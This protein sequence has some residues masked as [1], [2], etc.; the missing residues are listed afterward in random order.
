MKWSLQDTRSRYYVEWLVF[1]VVL[2]LLALMLQSTRVIRWLDNQTY[3]RL[4]SAQSA[5]TQ[6]QSDADPRIVIVTID[7]ESLKAN[8]QWPWPRSTHAKLLEQI[9]AAQP[10]GVALDLILTEPAIN[11]NDDR[12]LA[13]ALTHIPNSVL[14]VL[15]QQD[16]ANDAIETQKPVT[17]LSDQTR[18]GHINPLIDLDG[19]LREIPMTLIDQN[20]VTWSTLTSQLLPA[21]HQRPQGNLRIPFA[22][23]ADPFISIPY[24]QVLRGQV[25][26]ELLRGRYVL[27]GSTAL[28]LGDRYS[29]PVSGNLG[30]APGI[31]VHANI[32]ATL[33]DGSA[34]T[35]PSKHTSSLLALVPIGLLMVLLFF[36]HER[37]HL[38]VFI[39]VV[40]AYVLFTSYALW[41][42]HVWLPPVTTLLA[43]ALGY[44]LWSWRRLVVL[45]SHI[46]RQLHTLQD[47]TGQL[48]ALLQ[49]ANQRKPIANLLERDLTYIHQLYQFTGDALNHNPEAQIAINDIGEIVLANQKAQ[50][51]LSATPRNLKTILA[52]LA[53][54]SSAWPEWNDPRVR[55]WSW[56][57]ERECETERQRTYQLH[58]T[59]ITF[60]SSDQAADIWLISLIDLTIE[61]Q[62]ATQRGE[63]IKFLSHDMRSPQ[64]DIL[65][66]L[67][68]RQ[69]TPPQVSETELHQQIQERVYKTLDWAQEMVGL[70]EAQNQTLQLSE[71]NFWY[72]ADEALGQVRAQ[73]LAKNIDL[74]IQPISDEIEQHGWV[75]VDGVL[76]ERVLINLLNN[77][78]RYSSSESTIMLT[79][80]R[81][82]LEQNRY[83]VC[84]IQDQGY[85]ISTHQLK[86]LAQQGFLIHQPHTSASPPQTHALKC[87]GTPPQAPDRAG[88]LGV[89]L[90]MVATTIKQHGGCIYIKTN[91][92]AG[93]RIDLYLPEVH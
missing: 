83:I 24:D 21:E 38:W 37:L 28:G 19:V 50:N 86:Q 26:H 40:M 63:L 44:L 30:P 39:A 77:A 64:V 70:T 33:L 53:P 75:K 20:G 12:L 69:A 76:I 36:I 16:A 67:E 66:L 10:A 32:L 3:D 92:Q 54:N 68:L 2:C 79:F 90:K 1:V 51:I 41:Y 4:W 84:S 59:P 73:A 27:I 31:E 29:T 78:I 45:L 25:P 60:G 57:D 52:Q 9:A 35:S 13:Q 81:R 17:I 82:V 15:L 18:L 58:V 34:I 74:A 7:N 5:F 62:N 56:L 46:S 55:D 91:A 22:I 42:L 93:T 87:D 88:S 47:N 48:P 49:A 6:S 72:L 71:N 8:G 14:P 65:A 11:P 89:G 85:G 43:L 80:E 61:R 23:Q